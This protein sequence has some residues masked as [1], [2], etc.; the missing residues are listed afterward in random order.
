ME[1]SEIKVSSISPN[2]ANPRK[3]F[4]QKKLEELAESI[5]SV[6]IIQPLTLR[7]KG[8][9]YELIAGER[10]FRAAQIAG[11]KTVPATIR[12]LTDEQALE[13]MLLENMQREDVNP[14]EEGFGFKAL[15]DINGMK[16]KDIAG[17]IGKSTDYVLDRIR[18]TLLIPE[19]Q[20]AFMDEKMNVTTAGA[21]AKVSAEAQMIFFKEVKGNASFNYSEHYFN[22]FRGDLTKVSFD[23]KAADLFPGAPACNKCQFNTANHDLFPED[24]R[25]PRCQN[26]SCFDRKIKCGLAAEIEGAIEKGVLIAAYGDEGNKIKS[27]VPGAVVFDRHNLDELETEFESLEDWVGWQVDEYDFETPEE[28][29]AE[30]K[31]YEGK[32]KEEKAQWKLSLKDPEYKDYLA[33]TFSSNSFEYIKAK[34]YKKTANNQ[35]TERNDMKIADI[36]A[37]IKSDE[38]LTPELKKKSIE[39]IG[40]EIQATNEIVLERCFELEHEYVDTQLWKPEPTAAAQRLIITGLLSAIGMHKI[41]DFI[42]KALKMDE[43]DLAEFADIE[44]DGQ[45]DMI[46]KRL[47]IQS[48]DSTSEA[49]DFII[50][51]SLFLAGKQIKYISGYRPANIGV[52]AMIYREAAAE[53]FTSELQEIGDGVREKYSKKL[54]GLRKVLAELQ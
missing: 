51:T 28:Y 20:K 53:Q 21:A 30:L 6:G 44:D 35:Q 3:T 48:Q 7:K 38:P 37:A 17:R 49:A 24:A 25:K 34:P 26:I 40:Q 10:R 16:P 11:L 12:E 45:L 46:F 39:R 8:R 22:K 42:G 19:L 32:Y 18:L 13:I 54:D 15:R 2:P 52:K 23:K 50:V 41:E 31:K 36:K 29:Q 5:T 9:G 27:L 14:L 4:N 33:V 43:K 47:G 1:T